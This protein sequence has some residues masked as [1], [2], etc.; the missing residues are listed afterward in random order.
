[1]HQKR[2]SATTDPNLVDR[3]DE[4]RV[5]LTTSVCRT[6]WT[7]LWA[8][9]CYA[10]GVHSYH[11]MCSPLLLTNL[12]TYNV[13]LNT[14]IQMTMTGFDL[15]TVILDVARKGFP[16]HLLGN[17]IRNEI[18]C[19]SATA[20]E[21]CSLEHHHHEL[22]NC[23]VEEN[24]T[25]DNMI[26]KTVDVARPVRHRR[27]AIEDKKNLKKPSPQPA[28]KDVPLH[29]P[30]LP[31]PSS[32]SIVV[33]S[34]LV[35]IDEV[36]QKS[37]DTT[38]EKAH[39]RASSSSSKTS[40]VRR[41]KVSAAAAAAAAE[42][43]TRSDAV[44]DKAVVR[45]Q[46]ARYEIE[47]NR[48][49]ERCHCINFFIIKWVQ[50]SLICLSESRW[51]YF[52][53]FIDAVRECL[54]VRPHD[55]VSW[56]LFSAHLHDASNNRLRNEYLQKVKLQATK[57]AVFWKTHAERTNLMADFKLKC[58]FLS[59]W[60]I[61]DLISMLVATIEK[62]REVTRQVNAF[63]VKHREPVRNI[64]SNLLWRMPQSERIEAAHELLNREIYDNYTNFNGIHKM[65]NFIM[66]LEFSFGNLFFD[67]NEAKR[68]G[69]KRAPPELNPLDL[70]IIV[71]PRAA[72]RFIIYK[73]HL[74]AG[75]QGLKLEDIFY[76]NVF[77]RCTQKLDCL[78]AVLARENLH[79]DLADPIESIRIAEEFGSCI[80]INKDTGLYNP[81]KRENNFA[82][83]WGLKEKRC[84][85]CEE[86]IEVLLKSAEST[87]ELNKYHAFT[88]SSYTA[89]PTF[90]SPC[91]QRE[92]LLCVCLI[93][94]MTL[95]CQSPEKCK[96]S[97]FKLKRPD[98][99]IEAQ[100]NLRIQANRMLAASADKITTAEQY[101][102]TLATDGA[103]GSK[104]KK[105]NG[106]D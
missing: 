50:S 22:S 23:K 31:P 79:R 104:K 48:L 14:A 64:D 97:T 90:I 6:C 52:F 7:N 75:Y 15:W 53:P 102:Q 2:A 61:V 36:K 42:K 21:R 91:C 93:R 54:N 72:T 34:Q 98:V 66:A 33:V 20:L 39:A 63:A 59:C 96:D 45:A 73:W 29:I 76:R 30:D 28:K 82:T 13:S 16:H 5:I 103:G 68:H 89:I 11:C 38:S 35:E 26:C 18:S 81:S 17:I 51:I 24:E 69:N 83:I 43:R 37:N 101:S 12:Y 10:S 44:V 1:M 87:N 19:S 47:R 25:P 41:K 46:F 62:F 80:D 88:F 71:E 3:G 27:R 92:H 100:R 8:Y 94:C 57:L 105:I 78:T 95:I 32:G 65:S 86:E 9:H 55:T 4:G 60:V 56:T 106:I 99:F 70:G 74:F 67:R 58:F 85:I 84:T 77:K 40:S 49:I